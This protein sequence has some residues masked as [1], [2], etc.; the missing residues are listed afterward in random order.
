MLLKA[1]KPSIFGGT[2]MKRRMATLAA[3]LLLISTPSLLPAQGRFPLKYEA[4]RG[5]R[6]FVVMVSRRFVGPLEGKPGQLKGI[7]KDFVGGGTYFQVQLGQKDVLFALDGSKPPKLYVDT[8]RDGNL[9]DEKPFET[10]AVK[11]VPGAGA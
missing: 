10:A 6:D 5:D 3:L 1:A 4:S 8:N 11:S 9:S 7:P 2:R